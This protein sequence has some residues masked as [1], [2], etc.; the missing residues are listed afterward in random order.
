MPQVVEVKV[1]HPCPFHGCIKTVLY[2][3][4]P[5]ERVW[6]MEHIGSKFP[7][8]VLLYE[9]ARNLVESFA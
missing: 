2:V 8:S 1:W 3:S 9:V 5:L 6:V 4:V 7:L